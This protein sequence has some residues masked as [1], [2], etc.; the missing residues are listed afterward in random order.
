MLFS[1]LQRAWLALEARR[2]GKHWLQ[3]VFAAAGQGA[4]RRALFVYLTRPFHLREDHPAF[5]QH[6]SLRQSVI[7]AQQLAAMGYCVDVVDVSDRS[8]RPAQPYDLVLCH[9]SDATGLEAAFTPQTIRLYLASGTNHRVRN[10]RVAARLAEVKNRR[11][12]A[13]DAV[14]WDDEK[15]PYVESAHAIIGFGNEAVMGTWREFFHG[16]AYGFDNYGDF[17]DTDFGPPMTDAAHHFLFFGSR[18][19]VSKG[20]DLLLEVFASRSDLHLHICSKFR[21]EPDFCACYQRELFQTANIHAHGWVDTGS[22]KFRNLTRQCAFTILPSCSEGSPGSITNAITAGIIPMLS[23]EAG[24]D[25]NGFGIPLPE[26]TIPAIDTVVTAASNLPIERI[27]ELR[28][29]TRAAGRARFSA[30]AFSRRWQEILSEVHN[31]FVASA[32]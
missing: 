17:C 29:A 18:Q 19:Q 22:K 8:F 10:R 4:M 26:L 12:C 21:S 5:R 1:W 25:V 32:P 30:E 13:L 14:Q 23:S 16:P 28:A 20:L 15:M 6:Q 24:V 11:G 9:R 27:A 2:L 7:I 3:P 31:R